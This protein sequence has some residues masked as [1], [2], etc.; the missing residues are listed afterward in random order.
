MQ[1]REQSERA[2]ALEREA[3]RRDEQ[4][5]HQQALQDEQLLQRDRRIEQLQLQ[6]DIRTLFNLIIAG[7]N[8]GLLQV[9]QLREES[10]IRD[11]EAVQAR[12]QKTEAAATESRRLQQLLQEVRLCSMLTPPIQ[13]AS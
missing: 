10:S 8:V 13:L 6:V 1:L 7:D 9:T 2:E 5:A 4:Q 3:Q 11:A 12:R